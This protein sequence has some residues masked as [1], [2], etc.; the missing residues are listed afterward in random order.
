M[1][2]A[3]TWSGISSARLAWVAY[4]NASAFRRFTTRCLLSSLG[5]LIGAAVAAVWV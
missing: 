1:K 2:T 3:R 4:Q 5:F